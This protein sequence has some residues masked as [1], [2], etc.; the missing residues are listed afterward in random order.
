LAWLVAVPL[1]F[2]GMLAGALCYAIR[3]K[4]TLSD[5][6]TDTRVIYRSSDSE[7]ATS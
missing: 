3:G 7:P 1:L 4:R 5:L 6:L 2:L